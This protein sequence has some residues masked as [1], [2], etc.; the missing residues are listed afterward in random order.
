MGTLKI[1]ESNKKVQVEQGSLLIEGIRKIIPFETPCNG[2]GICGKCKVVATGKLNPPTVEELNFIDREKNQRLSCIARVLGDVEVSIPV[3]DNELKS[4]DKGNSIW[5]DIHSSIKEIEL[6]G[7]GDKKSYR[8]DFPYPLSCIAQCEKLPYIEGKSEYHG[9]VYQ[10][11]VLDIIEGDQPIMG[12]AIDIGTTGISYCLINLRN[13]E[14]LGK[15][16]SLNP[17]TQYGHDVLSRITYCMETEGG[18]R[19]LSQVLI[20]EIN[21]AIG[22]LTKEN[23]HIYHV[24]ISANTTMLHLLLQV[25]PVPLARAPYKPAFLSLQD[26]PLKELG[27]EGNREGILTFIPCASS[28]VGGDIVSGI[29]ALAFPQKDNSLFIDIGTNGEIAAI[30]DKNIVATS[31]AAGPALEGMNIEWGCRAQRGAIESFYIDEDYNLSFETIGDQEPIGICGSGLMDITA[32]LLQ[33]NI[34][35]PSGRWNKNMDARIGHRFKEKRFYITPEIYISQKDIRQIQLAKGAIAAG[36]LLLLKEIGRTI[37]EVN[38]LYIAGSFGF[39]MKGENLKAI[40]LIPED[41]KGNMVFVGN[42]S[43]EGARLSLLSQEFLEE[44][45]DISRKIKVLELSTNKDFQDVFVKELKF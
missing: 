3:R 38:T 34:L 40:G 16:S 19:V 11:V 27:I 25:D 33:R 42:T 37:H 44:A 43:L 31:T 45:Q 39:H 28:Y 2:R 18:G 4:I 41:F 26:R 9:V 29:M 24:S 23:N 7:V 6:I 13:G 35:L 8:R 14:I 30:F 22:T 15:S 17:Q 21:K 5:V 20:G 32:S 1:V 10:D 36:V 12:L